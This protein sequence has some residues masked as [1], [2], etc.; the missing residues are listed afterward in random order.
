MATLI[1]TFVSIFQA[2]T[3]D[4]RRGQDQARRSTDEIVESMKKADVQANK[5]G[6][7]IG[8]MLLRATAFIGSAIAANQTL[9]QVMV[10][11]EGIAQMDRTAKSIGVAIE[12]M[13]AFGRTVRDQGG[14]IEGAVG[15]I[16]NVYKAMGEAAV[17]AESEQAKQFAKIGV[18]LKDAQGNF[19]DTMDVVLDVA[20]AM[21]DLDGPGAEALAQ[22][23]GISD[24][25]SIEA[26]IR[27]REELQR[28]M[29]AQKEYGVVT[30]ETADR[31]TAFTDSMNYLRGG[32][33][34]AGDGLVHLLLPAITFVVDI[35]GRMVR[36]MH[37]N[38]EFVTGFFLAI[39]AVVATKFLP[40][41]V[42][43][44][45]AVLAATWP[46]LLAAAAVAGLAAMFALVYDDIRNFMAGNDSL[47]GQISEK[48]PALGRMFERIGEV[49]K[50]VFNAIGVVLDWLSAKFGANFGSI[51]DIIRAY[52][53]FLLGTLNSVAEWA[54]GF[55]QHFRDAADAVVGIFK[56]L[57]EQI[58]ELLKP[59][60]G[61]FNFVT[62]GIE[63]IGSGVRSGAGKVA[64]TVKGWFGGGSDNLPG[65]DEANAALS[66]AASEPMNSV[67]SSVINNSSRGPSQETNL[68]I[69]EITVNTQATDASGVARDLRSELA[70]QLADVNSQ[71]STGVVK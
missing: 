61:A 57:W 5:T 31:A 48:Y 2:D 16:E 6:A 65:V 60:T 27:G 13:D 4:L 56:W 43:A 25:R 50:T 63:G 49:V 21:E 67:T 52:F 47:I 54:E 58:Q 34:R 30:Q 26:M 7:S 11:G 28:Q 38:K 8:Q 24:R 51:T 71:Y 15:T 17:N 36:W 55:E 62:D 3:E 18:T 42:S 37:D 29:R 41:M 39:A 70:D 33:E 10:R 35:L 19:R 12:S 46:F 22:K 64:D 69:G 44:G 40:A 20:G 45:A 59:I 9:Q 53:R 32:M 68:Q 66:G 1:D 23:L 14:T